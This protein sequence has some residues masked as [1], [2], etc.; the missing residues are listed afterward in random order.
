MCIRDSIR[1]RTNHA[2]ELAKFP[3]GSCLIFP[4]MLRQ[5]V[6]LCEAFVQEERLRLFEMDREAI[7]PVWFHRIDRG[8]IIGPP[9]RDQ[10]VVTENHILYSKRLSIMPLYPFA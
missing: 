4:D 10:E 6:R 8:E 2:L 3:A 5:N 1:T 7:V 9:C